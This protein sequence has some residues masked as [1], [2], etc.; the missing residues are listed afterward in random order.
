MNNFREKLKILRNTYP[1]YIIINALENDEFE[2]FDSDI[3]KIA[4]FIHFPLEKN[5]QHY[6]FGG[7]TSI[8]EKLKHSKKYN[9][10]IYDKDKIICKIE[11]PLKWPRTSNHEYMIYC[12]KCR[13]LTYMF[14]KFSSGKC[15]CAKCISNMSESE[16]RKLNQEQFKENSEKRYKYNPKIHFIQGGQP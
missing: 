12:N 2:A 6:I 14:Y 15:F 4:K 1:N 9:V 10:I 5:I 8:V 11:K 7:F 16:I 13:T 3:Y